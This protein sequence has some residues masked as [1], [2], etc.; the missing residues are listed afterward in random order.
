MDQILEALPIGKGELLREGKDGAIVAIGT[1]VQPALQAADELAAE[2]VELAVLN[3]RFVKPLDGELILALAQTGRLFT[4]EENVLQ[5]G[6]GTA[7][8][9]LLEENGVT[10]V[11]VVRL[12]F[13]DSFVEQGEQTELKRA[14]GLDQ[15]GI[16]QS[17]RNSF[18]LK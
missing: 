5:G 8:L 15:E 2:G 10:G 16:V 7:I 9:E 14:F 1:M 12:G 6:F 13:P 4:V 17:I 11:Q 3:A 18:N